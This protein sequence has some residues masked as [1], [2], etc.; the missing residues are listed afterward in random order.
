M[1]TI[2]RF[3]F[4][5]FPRASWQYDAMVGLIVVFIFLTPREF[6]KDQLK[7]ASIVMLPAGQEP[8]SVYWLEPSLLNGVPPAEMVSRASA[9]I[10]ARY[11]VHSNVTLVE[12]VLD[13]EQEIMGYRAFAR[14]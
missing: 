11:K 12:P 13:D 1:G 9:L 6:F 2:V 5:D 8:G 7:P 4:W 14:Q 3:I 10:R